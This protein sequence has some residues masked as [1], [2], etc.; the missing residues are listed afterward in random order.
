MRYL[1][2]LLVF[3]LVAC[4]GGGG[5]AVTSTPTPA[6]NAPNAFA[7]PPVVYS[8]GG[9]VHIA[10]AAAVNPSTNAPSFVYQGRYV[11]PTIDVAPGDAIE[12]DYT[13]NL[14][15][16]DHASRHDESPLSR[17]YRFTERAGG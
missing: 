3:L 1:R 16:V 2:T 12:I 9:V 6:P 11:A 15:G 10:L 7:E 17:T 13:N 4:G 14:P 8:S 5:A